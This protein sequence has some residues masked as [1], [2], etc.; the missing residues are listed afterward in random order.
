MSNTPRTDA[1]SWSVAFDSE[2]RDFARTLERELA[3]AKAELSEDEGVINVWR[4]R[5][6][7]AEAEC[8]ALR[9]LLRECATQ[10]ERGIGESGHEADDRFQAIADAIDSALAKEKAS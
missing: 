4:G 2:K 1:I 3:A 5:T 7:R 8:E 10:A 9:A 6:Q